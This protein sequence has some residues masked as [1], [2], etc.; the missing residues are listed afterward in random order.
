MLL[1]VDMDNKSAQLPSDLISCPGTAE[2]IEGCFFGLICIG[3]TL[4]PT[5]HI[6]LPDDDWAVWARRVQD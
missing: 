3:I 2:R 5:F 1:D 6:N 4:P